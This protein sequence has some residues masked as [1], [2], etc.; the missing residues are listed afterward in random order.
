MTELRDARFKRALDHAP[1]TALKPSDATREA[2]KSIAFEVSAVAVPVPVKLALQTSP[3]PRLARWW[4]GSPTGSSHM[5]W[6]AALATVVLASLITL[7]WYEQPV[8]QAVPDDAPAQAAGHAAAEISA[9][10]SMPAP[11]VASDAQAPPIQDASRVRSRPER[12]EPAARQLTQPKP[13][14]V[15]KIAGALGEAKNETGPPLAAAPAPSTE[16]SLSA[17]GSVRPN[18]T[19]SLAAETTV[20]PARSSSPAPS[21]APAV[22]PMPAAPVAAAKALSV[23]SE[24][25]GGLADKEKRRADLG[26][27]A[28][29][30]ASALPSSVDWSELSVRRVGSPVVLSS[31]QTSRLVALLQAVSLRATEASDPEPSAATRLELSRRGEPV[32]T[33]DLGDRWLRWTPV[34]AEPRATLTGRASVAQWEAIQDELARLG[35]RAP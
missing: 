12:D 13:E 1:D 35:L 24:L 2:I 15:A 25:R 32:A 9:P 11:A 22:A 5:P 7:L 14:P 19:V 17:A 3:W 16:Q 23:Q 29:S 21:A 27:A 31:A 6:N 10:A 4:R 30:R 20:A 18:S 34:G 28:G 33:L 8:P 26:L